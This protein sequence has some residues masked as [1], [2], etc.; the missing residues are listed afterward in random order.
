MWLKSLIVSSINQL[1]KTTWH[2]NSFRL[3]HKI[4]IISSALNHYIDNEGIAIR[5]RT[6]VNSVEHSQII[7]KNQTATLAIFQ[8]KVNGATSGMERC[9]IL[10]LLNIDGRSKS[11][12]FIS[13]NNKIRWPFPKSLI[14]QLKPTVSD[15][16]SPLDMFVYTC[17][18]TYQPVTSDWKNQF[19]FSFKIL[20]W[21]VTI[22]TA[23]V[24]L[25]LIRR[26]IIAKQSKEKINL[27]DG[28]YSL[29]K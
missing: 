11:D 22:T 15:M 10:P 27:T 26:L 16:D 17:I 13:G 3:S 28:I 19:A 7:E 6:W 12:T 18:L 23:Y 29:P 21:T 8:S 25:L 2:G 24:C 9:C 1:S 4:K 20:V 14:Y 5:K